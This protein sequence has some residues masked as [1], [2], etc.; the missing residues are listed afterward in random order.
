VAHDWLLLEDCHFVC[1]QQL[2]WGAGT[3]LVLLT[4]LLLQ[5]GMSHLWVDRPDLDTVEIASL[6]GNDL[7]GAWLDVHVEVVL[8]LVHHHFVKALF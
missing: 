3:P 5:R 2:D 1:S 8:L 7:R 4:V 6:Q